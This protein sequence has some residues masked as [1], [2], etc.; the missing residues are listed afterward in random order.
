[1]AN[2]VE[3]KQI[4]LAKRLTAWDS[5][6]LDL[7]NSKEATIALLQEP[8]LKKGF[9]MPYIKGYQAVYDSESRARPRA[10]ILIHNSLEYTTIPSLIGPDIVTIQT[11]K[12]ANVISSVYMDSKKEGDI[13][14]PL[15]SVIDYALHSNSRVLIGGDFNAHSPVWGSASTNP[16]GAKVEDF[17]MNN[18]IKVDNVGNTY[19]YHRD[20][21]RTI[22]DLT[23]SS[24]EVDIYDWVVHTR[25]Q[26]SD[27]NLITY[28]IALDNRKVIK[29]R[30][31]KKVDWNKFKAVMATQPVQRHPQW[32][33][34][35][36]RL[37][38]EVEALEGRIITA[39][40]ELAPLKQVRFNDKPQK[41][42][43]KIIAARKALLKAKK[44]L[45]NNADKP[46]VLKARISEANKNYRKIIRSS[47]KEG[48]KD[49]IDTINETNQISKLI[50]SKNRP[51]KPIGM[52]S[53]NGTITRSGSEVLD[54]L[55]DVHFP[56]SVKGEAVPNKYEK[57]DLGK[58]HVASKVAFI[59]KEKV[60]RSFASFGAGKAAGDN[61]KPIVLQNLNDETLEDFVKI[62]RAS[63][64][65][66]TIPVNWKKAAVVFIPKAGKPPGEP[67]SLRPLTL[68]SFLLKGL[69]KIILWEL[70]TICLP[71]ISKHQFAFQ[72]GKSIDEALTKVVD[73]AE[74]G[75]LDGQY[76]MCVFLDI[77]GAF[78]NINVEAC[79][80]G[81]KKCGIPDHIIKWFK[82]L[83][84]NRVVTANVNGTSQTRLLNNGTPQ[85]DVWS[86]KLFCMAIDSILSELNSDGVTAVGFA[87][88]MVL[89]MV[90]MDLPTIKATLQLKANKASQLLK[91]LGLSL[92]AS[93]TE[94]VVFTRKTTE[95]KL[96]EFKLDGQTVEISQEAKYLGVI[97]DEK[98]LFSSHIEAKVKSAKKCIYMVRNL[99]YKRWGPLPKI[100]RQAYLTLV[101]PK[102]DY[103][104]HVWQHKLRKSDNLERV[105]SLALRTFAPTWQTMPTLGL[106]VIWNIPPLHLHLERRAKNIY[107]RIKDVIK[108]TH[109]GKEVSKFG[110]LDV[111][112]RYYPLPVDI[113]KCRKRAKKKLYSIKI[114]PDKGRVIVDPPL[115][116]EIHVY[117]DGSKLEGLAGCGVH[118][119]G[120]EDICK[121]LGPSAS[122]FQGEVFAITTAAKA[123]VGQMG[124]TITFR[125]DS[126][127]ALLA[128]DNDVFKNK[129][130]WECYEALNELGRCNEVQLRW[131]KAHIGTTGNEIADQ[132]AKRGSN[133]EEDR[134]YLP[135]PMA[136]VKRQNTLTMI[137]K[138]QREWD[139]ELTCSHTQYMLPKV[140]NGV[141]KILGTYKR[142]EVKWY[143]E[144]LTGF[145]HLNKHRHTMK[146]GD[147]PM[148]RF[149]CGREETP[150]HLIAVC[151]SWAE[152]RYQ[153]T[154]SAEM[155]SEVPARK[156]LSLL[157]SHRRWE[158]LAS[159]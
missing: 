16:R 86:P 141:Y 55:F 89:S 93:K 117:T 6:R 119:Q 40:D 95:V 4:N 98:L 84:Y 73:R 116:R 9:K 41:R 105:Q 76:T 10:V 74:R 8:Y 11:G 25:G 27:H 77:S 58:P 45:D 26:L 142:H 22:V 146:I 100:M 139:K 19:T 125:S 110:H 94:I 17:I 20:G 29:T 69:E 12:I 123:L 60:I 21:V 2:K 43:L 88:D 28:T 131:V 102:F 157:G 148:C 53:T 71:R 140:D 118:I 134:V 114:P 54:I 14:A 50:R 92:N 133:P 78:D 32:V 57:V 44:A 115:V 159:V 97:L 52:L 112:T 96:S 158:Q 48:Y 64:A 67:K 138:W 79:L 82:S 7:T 124:K 39:L 150:H 37:D 154:G 111:L 47:Q 122:V 87:D 31:L 18:P 135:I 15:Q 81:A 13:C 136:E 147:D 75:L 129:T 90:G 103:A 46:E 34:S 35:T 137:R 153:I 152:R 23:V 104:C 3:I 121:H 144:C 120:K 5:L 66:G 109:R 33:W 107:A 155:L 128:L 63:V 62:Y 99:V 65:L 36:T 70:E 1:M 113:D 149:G 156:V 132:L 80:D 145:C 24:M 30:H 143:L 106:Q 108:Q 68:G 130:T 127:A 101:V 91:A 85:G 72:P 42:D 59:T 49:F 38:K 126:Q 151:D 56:G 83:L 61:F 51:R